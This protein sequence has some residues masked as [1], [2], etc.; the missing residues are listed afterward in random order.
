MAKRTTPPSSQDTAANGE[1]GVRHAELPIDA[2][3][4]HPRNYRKH[5]ETQIKRLAS[6]VQRFGQVRSVVVQEGGA[7]R[8]LIVAGHGFIEAAKGSSCTVI[9]SLMKHTFL[10]A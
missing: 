4:P 3:K 2:L 10:R 7:G 9:G 8:Y 5:P 6:S 1:N